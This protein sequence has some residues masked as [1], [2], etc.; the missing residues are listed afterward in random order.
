ME[1]GAII[2]EWG[3][4]SL[5]LELDKL[6]WVQDKRVKVNTLWECLC[7]YCYMPRL[8][9]YQVLEGAIRLGVYKSAFAYA[10]DVKDGQCQGLK[11]NANL[12]YIAPSGYLVERE[13]ALK[14]LDEEAR[15]TEE[16]SPFGGGTEKPAGPEPPSSPAPS[17]TPSPG[18]PPKPPVRPTN[19]TMSA[20][21]SPLRLLKDLNKISDEILELIEQRSGQSLIKITLEIQATC[22][23]GFDEETRKSV[24]ENCQSLGIKF[25]HFDD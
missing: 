22:P 25:F 3:P 7:S 5:S 24:E 9:K 23:E 15:L 6:F 18:S 21:L 4:E 17:P 20:D 11:L 14:Q 13:E 16:R 19:F 2:E 10:E 8:A 12:S 1:N